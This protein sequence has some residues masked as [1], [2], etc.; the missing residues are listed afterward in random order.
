MENLRVDLANY[1]NM[2]AFQESHTLAIG[3]C[4]GCLVLSKCYTAGRKTAK[5]GGYLVNAKFG[6]I[7]SA[8]QHSCLSY[9]FLLLFFFFKYMWGRQGHWAATQHSSPQAD[10]LGKWSGDILSGNVDRRG[11]TS[12]GSHRPSPCTCR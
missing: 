9:S 10:C 5:A 11:I 3:N 1:K 6:L 4:L 7:I 12:A 8:C 2:F